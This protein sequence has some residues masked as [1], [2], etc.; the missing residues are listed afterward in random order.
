MHVKSLNK[1][2]SHNNQGGRNS[3][4]KLRFYIIYDFKYAYA[5][6]L[7]DKFNFKFEKP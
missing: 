6:E 7:I 5:S 4:S 3:T 2:I 1:I